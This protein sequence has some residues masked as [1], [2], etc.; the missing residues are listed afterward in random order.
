MILQGQGRLKE[1]KI[2]T[3]RLEQLKEENA[4]KFDRCNIR[5]YLIVNRRAYVNEEMIFRI[6]IVN[7]GGKAGKLKQVAEIVP[8][9]SQASLLPPNARLVHGS[10]EVDS[11]DLE[12]L[13]DQIIKFA[14]IPLETG[15]FNIK[16]KLVYTDYNGKKNVISINSIEIDVESRKL[17]V[18]DTNFKVVF[19]SKSWYNLQY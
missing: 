6:D 17:S 10:L 5:A 13:H 16:P 12:P 7:I 3:Q 19:K 9:T 11:K 4:A 8:F 15:T 14:I 2:Q 1:A 18:K